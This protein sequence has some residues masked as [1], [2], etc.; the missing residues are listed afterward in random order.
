MLP[1]LHTAVVRVAH[2][3]APCGIDRNASTGRTITG[4][5]ATG[6]VAEAGERRARVGCGSHNRVVT[7]AEDYYR[8]RSLWLEGVPGSLAPRPP[9]PG[10]VDCAKESRTDSSGTAR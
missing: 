8:T 3:D 7:T 4:L 2:V 1:L 6:D 9:L 5:E 10:D